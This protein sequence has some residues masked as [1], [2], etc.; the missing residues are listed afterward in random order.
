MTSHSLPQQGEYLR[1]ALEQE[2]KPIGFL[3]GA[4]APMSV[5]VDGNPLIPDLAT[6]TGLVRSEIGGDLG[7][8]L[9]ALIRHLNPNDQNNLEEVLNYVRTLAALPGSGDVRGVEVDQ[10]AVLDAEICKVVRAHVDTELPPDSTGYSALALWIRSVGRAE[11][12]QIFT[13]N[14]DLL[15]EQAL[16]RAMVA[17]FD[18][19]MGSYEPVFDIQAIEEDDLPSRWTLLWKL[20][21][22]INWAQDSDGNVVRRSAD[23]SNHETA[24]VYPSHL[25]YHQSRRLPYLAMM[26]RL[27]AF[28]RQPGAILVACGF[29]FKDQHINE[30][31]EQSL[32]NNPTAS[33]HGLLFDDLASYP[34]ATIL[35][36]RL[37][38]LSLLAKDRGVIGGIE[39]GWSP[40]VDGSAVRCDLGDFAAL[41][42]LLQRLTGVAPASH[43]EHVAHV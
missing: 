39:G 37:P 35:G 27:K 23:A 11:S 40:D 26:D 30:V 14:Y 2:K 4:G 10:L 31:I 43:Q 29:S 18:G 6:L 5:R 17:Y 33:L 20:H 8:S 1:A 12:T 28:L 19:F 9:D 32:R 36:K 21:G 15:I 16:E 22:S 25:K 24:L 38:N 42:S 34:E 41:G 3:L 13:T 7:E